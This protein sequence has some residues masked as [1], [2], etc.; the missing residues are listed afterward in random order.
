MP[1]LPLLFFSERIGFACCLGSLASPF[2][3]WARFYVLNQ[4]S[5]VCTIDLISLGSKELRSLG[6]ALWLRMSWKDS[7][8]S[9]SFSVILYFLFWDCNIMVWSNRVPEASVSGCVSF[10]RGVVNLLEEQQWNFPSEVFVATLVPLRLKWELWWIQAVRWP[11]QT[12]SGLAWRRTMMWQDLC[13]EPLAAWAKQC[14]GGQVKERAER[15]AVGVP[16]AQHVVHQ[17]ILLVEISV[18]KAD[19]L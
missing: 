8:R 15:W 14:K 7:T 3:S 19:T 5:L 13:P 2:P 10:T 9:K 4:R 16:V 17:G 1:A 6:S 12:V 11:F 18:G